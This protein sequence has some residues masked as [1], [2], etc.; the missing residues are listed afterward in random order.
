MLPRIGSRIILSDVV[1]DKYG[2]EGF[3]KMSQGEPLIGKYYVRN[4]ESN[5]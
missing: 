1:L 3:E 4:C 2:D 5:G